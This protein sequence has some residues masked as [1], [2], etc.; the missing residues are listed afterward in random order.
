MI[1]F[2]LLKFPAMFFANTVELKCILPI[3]LLNIYPDL[4]VSTEIKIL[5]FQLFSVNKKKPKY[6]SEFSTLYT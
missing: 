5:R 1:V 3:R 4:K 2:F 6:H